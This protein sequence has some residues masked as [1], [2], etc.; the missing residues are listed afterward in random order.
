MFDP[1]TFILPKLLEGLANQGH[2]PSSPVAQ[3]AAKHL[4]DAE[5]EVAKLKAEL[6][7]ARASEAHWRNLA[8]MMLR[9]R[10]MLPAKP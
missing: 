7:A 2:G 1:L 6:A 5:L 9:A 3:E 10:G 4:C 8:E